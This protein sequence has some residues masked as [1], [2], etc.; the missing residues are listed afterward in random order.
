MA[1][2]AFAGSAFTPAPPAPAPG[3][4]AVA[5]ADRAHGEI[6]DDALGRR[7]R[8]AWVQDDQDQNEGV[9]GGGN[10]H[11]P[12]EGPV[13]HPRRRSFSA[14]LLLL[15]LGHEADDF[16]PGFFDDVQDVHD[17]PVGQVFIGLE[18][19]D[20]LGFAGDRV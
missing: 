10:N 8:K 1:A 14:G 9:G 5:A 6:V 2:G 4:P 7:L 13:V 17:E 16:D 20:F 12:L 19:D 11:G 15:G 3:R 18:K